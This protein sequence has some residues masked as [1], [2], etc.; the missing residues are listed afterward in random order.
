MS[1]TASGAIR[2]GRTAVIEAA[3]EIG[4]PAEVVFG[5]CSDHTNEIEWNPAM[6]RVAKITDGPVGAG[7]RYE[8]EFFPGRPV[9]GECVRFDPPVSWA[10]EGLV[11]GMRSSFTGK[12]VPVPAGARLEVRME[13]ETRGL[14]RAALPLLRRRMPRNLERDIALIKARLENPAG[15]RPPR[16]D[17]AANADF[18][19]E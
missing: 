10:V 6:R 15:P 1:A 13:L 19:A 14:V 16:P 17:P 11:N 2:N 8:M 18:H 9:V 12:V 5:Y 3:T 4:C 7:T